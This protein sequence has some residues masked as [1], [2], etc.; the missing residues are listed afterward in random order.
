MFP[1]I[2]IKV[3][4]SFVTPSYDVIQLEMESGATAL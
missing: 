4:G 2:Y 3:E 1:I